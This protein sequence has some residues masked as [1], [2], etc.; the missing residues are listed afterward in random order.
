M[1]RARKPLPWNYKRRYAGLSHH[2]THQY[3]AIRR[4][5]PRRN[6]VAYDVDAPLVARDRDGSRHTHG[7]CGEF[8]HIWPSSLAV[9][10]VVVVGRFGNASKLSVLDIECRGDGG[11]EGG[12]KQGSKW[13]I[14]RQGR[15][16]SWDR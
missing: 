13:E 15:G 3:D 9:V 6:R 7:G 11:M 16:V 1:L 5:C 4:T 2:A 8:I 10:V 12:R 14:R